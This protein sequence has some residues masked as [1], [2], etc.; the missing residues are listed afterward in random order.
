MTDQ[1]SGI[2]YLFYGPNEKRTRECML[3]YIENSQDAVFY[4]WSI[5]LT[6]PFQISVHRVSRT[7]IEN[8]EFV[9][10]KS[11]FW[12][13]TKNKKIFL[14]I[15]EFNNKENIKKYIILEATHLIA[16]S[17]EDPVKYY[18]KLLSFCNYHSQNNSLHF[19]ISCAKV[20]AI[21]HKENPLRHLWEFAPTTIDVKPNKT[22][23][24]DKYINTKSHDSTGYVLDAVKEWTK[25]KSDLSL[26]TDNTIID[27]FPD[28]FSGLHSDEFERGDFY[29]ANIFTEFI[30]NITESS[31]LFNS[32]I[33]LQD[34]HQK[35]INRFNTTLIH[36]ALAKSN[37]TV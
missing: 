12:N 34:E 35:G 24:F 14:N 1:N 21:F 19:L 10:L 16:H 13:E 23:A 27:T 30:Q 20:P 17:S 36:D 26:L 37:Q 25:I 3:E 32:E 29:D 2:N 22:N 28:V 33:Y 5:P 31:L 18:K 4:P 7:N 11:Y 6:D 9:S 8:D 15:N